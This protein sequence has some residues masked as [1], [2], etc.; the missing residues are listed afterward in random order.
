MSQGVCPL[1]GKDDMVQRV[2]SL[3]T[4]GV[5][6]TSYQQPVAVQT[7]SGTVYGSVNRTL[8]TQTAL[9]R[10]LS[11]PAQPKLAGC[12]GRGGQW[13]VAIIGLLLGGL[14]VLQLMP[15]VVLSY[16]A[17][18]QQQLACAFC[19]ITPFFV[20]V[21]LWWFAYARAQHEKHKGDIVQWEAQLKRW[22]SLYYCARDDCVFD[23]VTHD[24]RRPEGMFELL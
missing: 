22:D 13:M 16:E 1:C 10:R 24:S 6:T 12:A 11:P 3:Y 19:G 21:T 2:S 14:L 8:S 5:S 15:E 7:Q 17:T 23:P 9:A 4:Q 18:K 20:L